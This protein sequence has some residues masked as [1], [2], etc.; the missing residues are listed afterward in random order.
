VE[1]VVLLVRE[2]EVVSERERERLVG[3]VQCDR[4]EAAKGS[5]KGMEEPSF[6]NLSLAVDCTL[7]LGS[8]TTR[9]E[10]PARLSRAGSPDHDLEWSLAGRSAHSE[11]DN[12][13]WGGSCNR[14]DSEGYY[15]QVINPTSSNILT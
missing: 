1:G 15:P 2:E 6:C 4:G 14:S 10:N 11:Q 5:V 12:L 13:S 3:V 8:T 9:T 7:S